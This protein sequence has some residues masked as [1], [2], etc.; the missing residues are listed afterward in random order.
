MIEFIADLRPLLGGVL[1][2]IDCTWRWH[3][4]YGNDIQSLVDTNGITGSNLVRNQ[5]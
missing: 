3:G 1:I 2:S 4:I 5:R